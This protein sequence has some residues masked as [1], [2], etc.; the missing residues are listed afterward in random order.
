MSAGLYARAAG[1]KAP[2]F[3]YALA[4]AAGLVCTATSLFLAPGE[5]GIFDGQSWWAGLL[6]VSQLALGHALAGVAFG[7]A[8]PVK[9]WRWGVWLCAASACGYSF[10][11]HAGPPFLLFAAATLAPA[12]A[13]SHVASRMA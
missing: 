2:R 9:G 12:C 8:W 13:G 10:H 11:V 5:G 6:M 7:L 1:G 4:A 3:S